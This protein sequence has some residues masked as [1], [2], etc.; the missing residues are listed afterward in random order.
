MNSQKNAF[1]G[2]K[3]SAAGEK[4]AAG[5]SVSSSGSRYFGRAA[6]ANPKHTD[7][8]S[9]NAAALNPADS[10]LEHIA[11]ITRVCAGSST[12]WL[13]KDRTWR[14]T[15]SKKYTNRL[16]VCRKKSKFDVL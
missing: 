11:G 16:D 14:D 6:W 12:D 2:S 15:S 13:A 9:R 4:S 8:P 10:A 5:V 3:G 7:P 1:F